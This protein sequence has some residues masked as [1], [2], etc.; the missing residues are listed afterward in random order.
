MRTSPKY[1]NKS[2]TNKCSYQPL[3]WS[4]GREL[5]RGDGAEAALRQIK[6]KGYAD[7]YLAEARHGGKHIII[8]GLDISSSEGKVADYR[9]EE[10]I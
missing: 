2:S 6:D 8:C 7:K 4:Q 1:T 9:Y 3:Q 5:K 10:V